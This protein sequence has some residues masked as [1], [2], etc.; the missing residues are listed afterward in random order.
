MPCQEETKSASLVGTARDVK[1]LIRPKE[2]D[3]T[4]ALHTIPHLKADLRPRF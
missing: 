1:N 4:P 3:G 2:G